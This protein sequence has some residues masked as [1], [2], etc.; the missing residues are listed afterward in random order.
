MKLKREILCFPIAVILVYFFYL[1][2]GV[3]LREKHL[4][5]LFEFLCMFLLGLFLGM[6]KLVDIKEKGK[7]R[8]NLGRFL[9][10]CIPPIIFLFFSIGI[11]GVLALGII[12]DGPTWTSKFIDISLGLGLNSQLACLWLGYFTSSS[13]CRDVQKEQT[14]GSE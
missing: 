11:Y 12:E 14:T 7:L 9:F 3:P 10:G 6:E 8:F 2:M 1:N 5:F 4:Y 13:F